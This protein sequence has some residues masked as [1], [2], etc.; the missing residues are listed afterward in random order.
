MTSGLFSLN[1]CTTLDEVVANLGGVLFG[2]REKM[3][4]LWAFHSIF[5]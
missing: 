3:E 5:L 4:K 1:K 2:E